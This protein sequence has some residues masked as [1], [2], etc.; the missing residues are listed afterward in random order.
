MA[1]DIA[2]TIVDMCVKDAWSSAATL[3]MLLTSKPLGFRMITDMDTKTWHASFSNVHIEGVKLQV[4]VFRVRPGPTSISLRME[5]N[6][7][8]GAQTNCVELCGVYDERTLY[9]VFEYYISGRSVAA[10]SN[11]ADVIH[12][13]DKREEVL[14]V[15]REKL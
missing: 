12:K 11:H 10:I 15:T 7:I 5:T 6:N 9:D 4:L 1:H 3:R 13:A 8:K 14:V 2:H